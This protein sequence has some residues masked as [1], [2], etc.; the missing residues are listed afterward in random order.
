MLMPLDRISIIHG[1]MKPLILKS[2]KE[3]DGKIGKYTINQSRILTVRR[4]KIE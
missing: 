4:Y 2:R 1:F 3:L